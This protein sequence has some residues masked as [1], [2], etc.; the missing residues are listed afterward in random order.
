MKKKIFLS[1]ILF[2]IVTMCYAQTITITGQ[3]IDDDTEEAMPFCNVF[4]S[5]S[6]T[7]VLTDI[8]GNYTIQFDAS[9]GDT[10][11]TKS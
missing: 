3:V 7:G 1:W 2:M 10:L 4:V 11:V 5:G 8:D 6:N 9:I